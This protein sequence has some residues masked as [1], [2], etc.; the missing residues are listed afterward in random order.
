MRATRVIVECTILF[1]VIS[2][3]LFLLFVYVSRRGSSEGSKV[4][5]CIANLKQIQGATEQWALENHK[6]NGEPVTIWDISGSDTNYI[7][8][9]INRDFK[10]PLGGTYKITTVDKNPTCTIPG[11]TM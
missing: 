7:K 9:L 3:L 11:H 5:Q 4:N 8:A 1:V 6:T 10:C 2:F